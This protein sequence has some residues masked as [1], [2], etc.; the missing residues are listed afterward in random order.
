MYELLMPSPFVQI[1]RQLRCHWGRLCRTIDIHGCW[2]TRDFRINHRRIRNA[3][4]NVRIDDVGR[5][6]CALS[7]RPPHYRTGLQHSVEKS[8]EMRR[9]GSVSALML[10]AVQ[11]FSGCRVRFLCL[12]HIGWQWRAAKKPFRLRYCETLTGSA[13]LHSRLRI[14]EEIRRG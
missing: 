12:S 13:T 2:M 6:T 9:P 3:T 5:R 14:V 4:Q 11:S 1:G 7:V 8:R 10:A